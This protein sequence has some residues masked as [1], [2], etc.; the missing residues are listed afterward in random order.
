MPT[1]GGRGRGRR[2]EGRE[3][4][5]DED[6]DREEDGEER[7]QR[8]R[9]MG[10]EDTRKFVWAD[11]LNWCFRST[12]LFL[13]PDARRASPRLSLLLL[14]VRFFSFAVIPSSGTLLLA[15]FSMLRLIY[16]LSGL[17]LLQSR[18]SL[19]HINR[20]GTLQRV[21]I[22]AGFNHAY[23]AQFHN[24]LAAFVLAFRLSQPRSSLNC[25]SLC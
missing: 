3:D 21:V 17:P 14:D 10:G 18:S 4:G 22:S 15:S 12:I 8:G 6:E 9:M 24:W 7:K 25:H 13:G 2:E 11:Y 19:Y 16:P 23:K 1:E 5:E 20:S